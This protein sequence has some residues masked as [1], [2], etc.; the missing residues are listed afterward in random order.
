MSQ[1]SISLRSYVETPAVVEHVKSRIGEHRYRAL[2]SGCLSLVGNSPLL[3]KADPRSILGAAIKAATLDLSIEPSLGHAYI[4]PYGNQAQFQIG[5][6]GLLQ[7]AQR[8]RALKKFTVFPVTEP[9]FVSWNPVT[10][11]L[12]VDGTKYSVKDPVVGYGC[13]AKLN[14]KNGGY[15]STIYWTREQVEEHAKK[16]S[17]A[18]T[19]LAW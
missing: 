3:A 16:Y 18:F 11:D 1:T 7:L 6:K 17:K 19:I 5:W 14:K 10:A 12:K 4:V 15:T 2:L 8:S 13:Y 9:M